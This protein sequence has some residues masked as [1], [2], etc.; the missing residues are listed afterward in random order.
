MWNS[1]VPW[2]LRQLSFRDKFQQQQQLEQTDLWKMTHST[3]Y[4]V[5]RA[6][7]TIVDVVLLILE[8]EHA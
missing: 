8:T 6:V 5:S 7:I 1:R 2:I 4:E 3:P